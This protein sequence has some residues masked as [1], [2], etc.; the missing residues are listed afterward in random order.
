[1]VVVEERG[2]PMIKPN[3]INKGLLIGGSVTL[4]VS[5]FIVLYGYL[6]ASDLLISGGVLLVLFSFFFITA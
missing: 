4:L 6:N 1:M 2:Y 3:R 5:I